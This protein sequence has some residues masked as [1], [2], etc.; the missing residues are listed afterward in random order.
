[1]GRIRHSPAENGVGAG[2]PALNGGEPECG[3]GKVE[4]RGEEIRRDVRQAQHF[5]IS[6]GGPVVVWRQHDCDG[7]G[8][9]QW[10]AESSCQVFITPAPEGIVIWPG[11]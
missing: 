3:A 6:G 8:V 1:M 2:G 11:T 9:C 5:L 10:H 7:F 4:H